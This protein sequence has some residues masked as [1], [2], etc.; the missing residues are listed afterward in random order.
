MTTTLQCC[1]F[2]SSRSRWDDDDNGSR[3][4]H[5]QGSSSETVMTIAVQRT[6]GRESGYCY[7]CGAELTRGTA[8]E[9]QVTERKGGYWNDR[10][11]LLRKSRIKNWALCF[12]CKKLK[13]LDVGEN[14][15]DENE[16]QRVIST[17][18]ALAPSGKMSQVFRSE[19][20]TI[21][22]VEKAVVVLCVDSINWSGTLISK[23]RNYV[24]GHPILLAVTRCDL[25]PDY[26]SQGRSNKQLQRFFHERSAAM[27]QPANIYLCSEDP[28]RMHQ[29]GGIQALAGDLWEHLDGRDPYIV[30]A[31]NIGKSTLTDILIHGFLNRG[32]RLQHFRDKLARLRVQKLREARV[33]K[34]ALAGTTLGNIRVPCFVDHEQALWDTPGLALDESLRHFPI[35][36]LQRLKALRPEPIL[37]QELDI[38][39][40]SFALLVYET[41]DQEALPL[42]RLEVRQKKADPQ[43]QAGTMKMVWNST[44]RILSTKVMELDQAQREELARAASIRD[45]VHEKQQQRQQ[46]SINDNKGGGSEAGIEDKGPKTAAER[47]QA[48]LDRQAEFQARLRREVEEMGE[49]AYRQRQKERQEEQYQL[50]RQR[51][52]AKL[53]ETHK[54]VIPGSTG[55][56]VAVANMG[57]FGILAPRTTMIKCFAPNTGVRVVHHP[58]MGLPEEWGS[59]EKWDGGEPMDTKRKQTGS[60]GTDERNDDDDDGSFL[61]GDDDDDVGFDFDGDYDDYGDFAGMDDPLS[62]GLFDN[63]PLDD[64]FTYSADDDFN[65]N[66][67]KSSVRY[68][69]GAA[70]PYGHAPGHVQQKDPWERYSGAN[71]GWQFDTDTRYSKG[72]KQ[73]GWNPIATARDEPLD[74][75]DAIV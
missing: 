42:L 55:V 22:K 43:A 41:E 44:L 65:D 72:R 20:S 19:V 29:Y 7:G 23:I 40:K 47:R 75:E 54:V 26:I 18:S 45:S 13:N 61:V 24:G 10:K 68:V 73:E 33:T 69:R 52:L 27:V 28:V 5:R 14:H 31:A 37:A 74:D 51:Q 60:L 21:R 71:V 49:K 67:D 17:A 58:T 16:Q 53:S 3:P 59:Y 36:D 4:E 35:R 62:D 50:Y 63:H 38:P 1:R 8:Q 39:D 57:W 34:S 11:A 6:K 15:E 12:R 66:D 70:T 56:D 46:Q 64:D 48:R 32:E 30:G 9:V 25:L 2:A